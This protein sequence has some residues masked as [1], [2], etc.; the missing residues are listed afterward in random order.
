MSAKDKI[1]KLLKP[2]EVAQMLSIPDGTLRYWR[3]IGIGPAFVKLEG[4][5]RYDLGDVLRYIEQRRRIPSV[6]AHMEENDVAL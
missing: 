2:K 5:I 1:P 4:S 6:R 3:N